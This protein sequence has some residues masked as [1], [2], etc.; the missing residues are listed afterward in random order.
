[1]KQLLFSGISAQPCFEESEKS[2]NLVYSILN[3]KLPVRAM[4][5]QE[6]VSLNLNPSTEMNR[7]TLKHDVII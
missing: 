5:P 1:M 6:E 2:F 7:L 3:T 4:N